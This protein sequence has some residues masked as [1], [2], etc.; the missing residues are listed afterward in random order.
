LE[1]GQRLEIGQLRPKL[2]EFHRG[3]SFGPAKYRLR[4][5][6]Y[7]FQG[8]AGGLELYQRDYTPMDAE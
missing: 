2:I 1:P 4:E 3:G 6:V 8:T 5:A 7:T